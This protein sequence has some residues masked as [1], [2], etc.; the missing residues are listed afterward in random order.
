MRS[1]SL[2]AL[3]L[4]CLVYVGCQSSSD[5]ENTSTTA[6]V[7]T[8][9]NKPKPKPN[10]LPPNLP[11][12][13]Q[14][15]DAQKDVYT[16]WGIDITRSIP[17]GLR[18]GD[19]APVFK[20]RD[21]K[22]NDLFLPDLYK[23]GPLVMIFYRG[24]WCP[25]CNKYL[26]ALQD[27]LYLLKKAGATVIAI[28]PETPANIDSTVAKTGL[29]IPVLHDPNGQLMMAYRIGFF[30]TDEYNQKVKADFAT[31]IAANNAMPAAMLPVPVTYIIDKTGK[32]TY[33]QFDPDFHK[34]A[35]VQDMLREVEKLK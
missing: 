14:L 17:V 6:T 32:I 10:K 28:T 15:S 13:M 12:E 11:P 27:S 22:G 34:R 31:D 35:S 21:N 3:A 33:R 8:V 9:Q 2:F 29:S 4:C 1:I 30:V 18:V 23:E 7:D 24:D 19:M 26:S 20:S 16:K 25:S 5:K